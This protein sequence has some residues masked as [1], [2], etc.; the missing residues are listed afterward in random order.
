MANQEQTR[1]VP[2]CYDPPI[3]DIN[4]FIVETA[5]SPERLAQIH[6]NRRQYYL[7]LYKHLKKHKK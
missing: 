1:T 6:R 2:E 5:F 7:G 3:E 4:D